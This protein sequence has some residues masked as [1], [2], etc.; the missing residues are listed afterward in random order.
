MVE[1]WWLGIRHRVL[2]RQLDVAKERI[3]VAKLST[4]DIVNLQ[5]QILDLQDQLHELCRPASMDGS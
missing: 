1:E 4:G 5:K 3:K 2:R